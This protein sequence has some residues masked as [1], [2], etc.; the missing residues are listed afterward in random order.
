[1][2]NGKSPRGCGKSRDKKGIYM[3]SGSE[4]GGGLPMYTLICDPIKPINPGAMGIT[5][6]GVNLIEVNGVF[7]VFDWVGETHYP[8]AADFLEE[9]IRL[10]L[11]RRIGKHEDFSKLTTESKLI[12]IHP[13]AIV[14][15]LPASP[16]A[17]CPTGLHAY[18]EREY[19][20]E[21]GKLWLAGN[22]KFSEEAT[23]AA[24]PIWAPYP[25]TEGERKRRIMPAFEYAICDAPEGVTYEPGIIMISPIER[26]A[27]VNDPFDPEGTEKAFLAASKASVATT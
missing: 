21:A 5:P 18:D 14:H 2:S 17:P 20:Y 11:S 23:E 1:M 12:L 22:P 27:V 26:L 3:E 9:A 16:V 15:G 7:H 4:S 25:S 10:G 19:I 24:Y 13:K 8:N 6:V